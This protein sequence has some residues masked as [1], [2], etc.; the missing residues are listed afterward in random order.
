MHPTLASVETTEYLDLPCYKFIKLSGSNRWTSL[1]V[2]TCFG[3]SLDIANSTSCPQ[4]RKPSPRPHARK[5]PWLADPQG[6][7]CRGDY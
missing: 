2:F 7:R 3:N 6:V 4:L 1:P 5:A